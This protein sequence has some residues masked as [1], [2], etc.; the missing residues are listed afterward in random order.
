MTDP[1]SADARLWVESALR[2]RGWAQLGL[3]EGYYEQACFGCQQA[4]E[5]ILKAF[6]LAH[7]VAFP[8]IHELVRLVAL[9]AELD[10]RAGRFEEDARNI[11]GYYISTR[12]PD[13]ASEHEYT[14]EEAEEALNVVNDVLVGIQALIEE[15]LTESP[16]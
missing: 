3:R 14:K 6:L 11:D 15:R 4:F 9:C 2:D 1:L 8:K 7:G 5:K 10:Q 13:L 12:Y 16:S